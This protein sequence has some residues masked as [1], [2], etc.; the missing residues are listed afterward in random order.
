MPLVHVFETSFGKTTGRR[1]ILVTVH[2][3]GVEGWGECVAGEHP[4]YSEE[5]VETAWY[6]LS[7]YFAPAL[8][9][10]KVES[11][12]DVPKMFPGVRGHRMAKGALENAVWDAEAI[13]KNVPLYKLIGGSQ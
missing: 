13:A 1:I 9:G 7:Q 2:G 4:F 11:G 5:A 8:A 6:T 3:D 12:R 10:K